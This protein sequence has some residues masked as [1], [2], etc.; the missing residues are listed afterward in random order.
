MTLPQLLY[1]LAKLWILTKKN[2]EEGK[3]E[4]EITARWK[5]RFEKK[6]PTKDTRQTHKKAAGSGGQG[7]EQLLRA[8]RPP[9][10]ELIALD[11]KGKGPGREADLLSLPD[12]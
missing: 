11:R 4:R 6:N 2:T 1:K 10:M 12:W 7:S 5:E 8:G 3:K 9:L